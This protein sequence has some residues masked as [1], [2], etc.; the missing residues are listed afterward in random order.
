MASTPPASPEY[1]AAAGQDTAATVSKNRKARRRETGLNEDDETCQIQNL[2][3]LTVSEFESLSDVEDLAQFARANPN[4]SWSRN[5]IERIVS[6]LLLRAPQDWPTCS[7]R[8]ALLDKLTTDVNALPRRLKKFLDGPLEEYHLKWRRPKN[9]CLH[10]A[11]LTLNLDDLVP[12]IGPMSNKDISLWTP[13]EIE[14]A[15]ALLEGAPSLDA[16]GSTSEARSTWWRFEEKW[17]SFLCENPAIMRR[18]DPVWVIIN[19]M[20]VVPP[21][22]LAAAIAA[23]PPLGSP[24]PR[25][26]PGLNGCPY[27]LPFPTIEDATCFVGYL[28]RAVP[29]IR[30]WITRNIAAPAYY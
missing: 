20:G 16:G 18:V 21:A 25:P 27:M 30:A 1:I 4:G 26:G 24:S 6:P 28:Y 13:A 7:C 3:E 23:F 5:D 11:N 15:V 10:R 29:G 22:G 12:V 17:Q 8:V 2:K 19:V 9:D 14:S